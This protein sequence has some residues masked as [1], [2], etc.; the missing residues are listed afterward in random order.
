MQPR[1]RGMYEYSI[2]CNPMKRDVSMNI[3]IICNHVKRDEFISFIIIINFVNNEV[4]QGQT[5]PINCHLHN[6]HNHILN[7]MLIGSFYYEMHIVCRSSLKKVLNL[8][9]TGTNDTIHKSRTVLCIGFKYC[10]IWQL[11]IKVTCLDN[12][13]KLT[14][15]TIEKRSLF[16]G[17]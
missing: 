2:I 9:C 1:R 17:F 8:D 13:I 7:I 11:Q 5:T 10:S 3:S 14:P 16:D 15:E 12:I 4:F 6:Q